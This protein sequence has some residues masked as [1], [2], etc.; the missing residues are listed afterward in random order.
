MRVGEKLEASSSNS[1]NK[2]M[3]S[4]PRGNARRGR[5]SDQTNRQALLDQIKNLVYRRYAGD[6]S[7]VFM[8]FNTDRDGFLDFDELLSGLERVF[9]I[10]PDPQQLW[11]ALEMQDT[12]GKMSLETF[13]RHFGTQEEDLG[14]PNKWSKNVSSSKVSTPRQDTN[15]AFRHLRHSQSQN[16]TRREKTTTAELNNMHM[17]E[18]LAAV[19]KT[20][21]S[22]ELGQRKLFNEL[23]SGRNKSLDSNELHQALHNLGLPMTRQQTSSVIR[24]FDRDGDHALS[25]SEFVR[26]LSFVQRQRDIEVEHA[27]PRKKQQ[28]RQG[29]LRPETVR[30]AS[31]CSAARKQREAV[32][33]VTGVAIVDPLD[34]NLLERISNGVYASRRKVRTLFK[35]MDHDGTKSL[36]AEELHAGLEEC[37]VEGVDIAHA[38]ALVEHFSNGKD[39]LRYSSFIKMLAAPKQ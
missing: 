33:K 1:N 15:A 9:W 21:E 5:H 8:A 20:L 3:F 12:N 26:L 2:N 36:N 39:E 16:P 6:I 10:Q 24:M 25:Y 18:A 4:S 11:E 13:A 30:D 29:T 22:T 37:G 28:I 34:Y 19:L 23:D 31:R 7:R 38:E 14:N 35:L 27:R 17:D 32:A